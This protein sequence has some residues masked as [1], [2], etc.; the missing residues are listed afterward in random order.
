MAEQLNIALEYKDEIVVPGDSR[1]TREKASRKVKTLQ[2]QWEAIGP[3]P[4][5]HDKELWTRYRKAARIC[6]GF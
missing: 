2:E 3:V 5:K 6:S 4:K 1:A